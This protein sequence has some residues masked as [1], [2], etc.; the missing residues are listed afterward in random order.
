MRAERLRPSLILLGVVSAA[1]VTRIPLLAYLR[2]YGD[3][4]F[5]ALVGH[6]W[7]K[8]ALPYTLT[9]D[10]KPPGLFGLYALAE[11]VTGD[12]WLAPRL[13]PLLAT[14]AA[15]I[16]LWRIGLA[17]FADARVGLLA[18]LFYSFNSLSLE[19][20][21]GVSEILFA[22][23]IVFGMLFAGSR[24]PW[25]ACLSGFLL[26]CAFVIKQVA[27]FEG[28][29]ALILLVGANRGAGRALAARVAGFCLCGAIPGVAIA[30]YYAAHGQ[31]ALL[32]DAAVVSAFMR[33]GGDGVSITEAAQLFLPRFRGV[34]PLLVLAMFAVAERR[35]IMQGGQR[36]GYLRALGWAAA[37]GAGAFALRSM[38]EH[39]FLTLV[40]PLSL[41]SAA[42]VLELARRWTEGA[43]RL[44]PA[45]L[46]I[47]LVAWPLAWVTIQQ[48]WPTEERHTDE[49]AGKLLMLGLRP[50]AP[51]SQLYVVDHEMAV[52]LATDVDPPARFSFPQH[53][54]CDF[55]LPKGVDAVRAIDD[56]MAKRPKFV[57]VTQTRRDMMCTR[58][59]RMA[60]I[61]RR[62][63]ADYDL[64]D[65]V[66]DRRAP[67]Q[68]YRLREFRLSR[69]A[70]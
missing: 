8:G 36:A 37:S 33:T 62:L 65:R 1:L 26:G 69:R 39:Y 16:G 25:R 42:F 3:E 53:L 2:P 38:Y 45:A 5:Y 47:A 55:Q 28:L 32:W 11:A 59:D 18:A 70:D 61:D 54:T 12:P 64:V 6:E 30:L 14:L 13:L 67:L 51:A 4:A 34:A 24:E 21:M 20:A 41:V 46:G 48:Q 68:I 10:V 44:A 60:Q 9:W 49:L 63:E 57:V 52:Y 56:I 27:A 17:W 15:C 40:A 19:G 23:F 50:D 58:P 22:P 29:C 31:F 35:N 43:R 7:L 66:D